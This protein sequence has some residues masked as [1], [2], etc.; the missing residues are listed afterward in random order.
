VSEIYKLNFRKTIR[1]TV[2][3][4]GIPKLEFTP[5][6][7]PAGFLAFIDKEKP[8]SHLVKLF[9]WLVERLKKDEVNIYVY[10]YFKEPLS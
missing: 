6:S 10:E 3:S 4:G 2:V 7:K 1:S 8:E 9:E 5:L